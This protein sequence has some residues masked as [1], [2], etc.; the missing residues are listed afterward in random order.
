MSHVSLVSSR[1]VMVHWNTTTKVVFNT[2]RIGMATS[3]GMTY[4]PPTSLQVPFQAI[5]TSTVSCD[6]VNFITL[7]VP[8]TGAWLDVQIQ[9]TLEG[10]CGGQVESSSFVCP[11][12]SFCGC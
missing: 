7:P 10:M 6:H 11:T 1:F 3:T 9:A 5:C 2:I 12:G 8:Q 4:K